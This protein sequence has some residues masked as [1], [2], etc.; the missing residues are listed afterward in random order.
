MSATAV[1]L[2]VGNYIQPLLT[3]PEGLDRTVSH[4]HDP[5][6]PVLTF[7]RWQGRHGCTSM[8]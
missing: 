5:E 6:C 4:D 1:V 7:L 2:K 8:P 3:H